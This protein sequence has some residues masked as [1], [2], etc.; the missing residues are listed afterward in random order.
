MKSTRMAALLALTSTVLGC[1]QGSDDGAAH[2]GARRSLFDTLCDGTRAC[3]ELYVWDQMLESTWSL[4][5]LKD[6]VPHRSAT[7]FG[8]WPIGHVRSRRFKWQAEVHENAVFPSLGHL[9]VDFGCDQ[10]NPH[11]Y[12]PFV[13][14]VDAP[15]NLDWARLEGDD[16]FIPFDGTAAIDHAFYAT[17]VLDAPDGGGSQ[18]VAISVA[19][20]PLV[21]PTLQGH[22]GPGD[23]FVWGDHRATLIRIVEPQGGDLGVIGWVEI[24]LSE[25]A[26]PGRGS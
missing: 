7:L 20:P 18:R 15:D 22:L 1:R 8:S 21:P 19:E 23:S 13:S 24:K 12:S 10:M 3:D 26:P 25:G 11:F 4:V 2:R 17:A 5:G 16:V 6:C 9:D 14:I